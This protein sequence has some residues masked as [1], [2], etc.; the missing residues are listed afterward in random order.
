M[1]PIDRYFMGY[2]LF[3]QGK[4]IHSAFW[5]YEAI[6]SFTDSDYNVIVDFTKEKI[7]SLYGET[8]VKQS[9]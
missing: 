5:T 6:V 3:G 1:K 9:E 2:Y 8:L 7:Y 4:Y